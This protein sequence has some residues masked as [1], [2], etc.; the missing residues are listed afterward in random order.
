MVQ[1]TLSLVEG[2]H[3]AGL[4][5]TSRAVAATVILIP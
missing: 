3:D 2:S 4:L 5:S 1:R